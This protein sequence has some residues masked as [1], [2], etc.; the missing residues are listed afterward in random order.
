MAITKK[1]VST[2]ATSNHTL[3]YDLPLWAG[4]DVTSWMG[5]LND[6]FDKIDSG[7]FAAQQTADSLQ[8]IGENLQNLFDETS[9]ENAKIQQQL[10]TL[11]STVEQLQTDTQSLRTG[12]TEAN[13]AITQQNQEYQALMAQFD[14]MQDD[15]GQLTTIVDG[16][17][18]QFTPINLE[19]TANGSTCNISRIRATG[20]VVEVTAGITIVAADVNTELSFVLSDEIAA[21]IEKI[22]EYLE[23]PISYGPFNETYRMRC[24]YALIKQNNKLTAR[25]YATEPIQPATFRLKALVTTSKAQ[26][27]EG[28]N[29]LLDTNELDSAGI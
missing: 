26:P 14:A 18:I 10:T 13:T 19:P 6:A 7:I 21:A 16:T 25:F 22:Y 20:G 12:L 3:N 29:E 28:T 27:L 24:S 15:I 2:V 4:G 23:S 17:I 8:E 5:N 11:S 9:E 1:A